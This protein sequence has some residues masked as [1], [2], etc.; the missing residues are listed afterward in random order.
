MSPSDLFCSSCGTRNDSEAAF[1][2]SCGARLAKPAAPAVAQTLPPP[3]PPPSATI[4]LTLPAQPV[5]AKSNPLPLLLAVGTIVV[6]LVVVLVEAVVIALP[7]GTVS[8]AG[9]ATLSLLQG[10]VELQ[11]GGHGDW[12]EV[13]QDVAVEAGD[14]IRTA[15]ASYAVLSFM[16]CTTTE[17]SALTELTIRELQVVPGKKVVIKLDLGL[18]EIWNRIAELPADSL[19]EVTTLA[20]TVTCRGSEYGMAADEMGTTWVRG[21]EGRVEVTGAGSTVPAAPGDT[22]VVELGSAPV[23]YGAVAM[24]PTAPVQETTAE[25]TSSI[26]GADMPTFLNQPLPSA[27]PTDTPTIT[28]TTRPPTATPPRPTATATSRPQPT[29]TTP[30]CPANCPTFQINVPSTAPPYG[31]FGLEWDVLGGSVP[32][33]Y[34]YV[35]E[36]SQDQAS[37]GRTPPLRW[38]DSQGVGELWQEGG[39]TKAEIHGAGPG[40]WFWRVCIVQTETGPSCCCGPSHGIVHQRDD[41]CPD[42]H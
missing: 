24:V 26:Q 13:A 40:N 15:D 3:P 32:A 41:T 38:K 27:T 23:S 37:W 6:L 39:H 1:C 14:R 5:S 2:S 7:R 42:G 25:V 30:V 31:L 16:E 33:G 9:S 4:P 12:I 35:L 36:F 20:A 8:Q 19:H 21:Q 10:Q 11:K 29:A 18:G 28:P 17:L 22:L 34:S